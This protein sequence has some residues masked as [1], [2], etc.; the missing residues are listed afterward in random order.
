M[1][2]KSGGSRFAATIRITKAKGISYGAALGDMSPHERSSVKIK[3]TATQLQIEI[4]AKDAAA[5]RATL[6]SALKDLHVTESVAG[7]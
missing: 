3:E 1:P 7:L 4:T 6:N 5:L 2:A